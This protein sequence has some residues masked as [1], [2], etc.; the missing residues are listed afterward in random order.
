MTQLDYNVLFLTRPFCKT[1]PEINQLLNLAPWPVPMITGDRGL[2]K[3]GITDRDPD[4]AHPL[5]LGDCDIHFK[6]W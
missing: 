4:D 1:D 2:L 6:A 3:I 5:P